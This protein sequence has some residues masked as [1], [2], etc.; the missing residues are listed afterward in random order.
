MID[1]GRHYPKMVGKHVFRWA[2]DKMP[3]VA[4]EA[5]RKAGLSMHDIDLFI[6]HQANMRINQMVAARLELP[7]ESERRDR[8][9]VALR[10]F[11]LFPHL[12]VLFCLMVVQVFVCIASWFSIAFT[13]R[14]SDSL[15]RFTRDVM[16]YALRIETYALLLHDRFP[17]FSLSAEAREHPLAA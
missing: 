2:I 3:E 9:S 8:T 17:S 15:W 5:V 1:E 6:P 7:D 12:V 14:L 11:L 10:L 4:I 13:R 16:S